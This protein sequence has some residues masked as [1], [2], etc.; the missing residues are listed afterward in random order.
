MKKLTRATGIDRFR[1]IARQYAAGVALAVAVVNMAPETRSPIVGVGI[2]RDRQWMGRFDPSEVVDDRWVL[3]VP[4]AGTL[5]EDS[6]GL[7]LN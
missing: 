6:T 3:T 4:V 1:V 2:V 5:V 7:S